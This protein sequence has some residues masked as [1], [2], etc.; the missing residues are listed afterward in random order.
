[1]KAINFNIKQRTEFIRNEVQKGNVKI[2]PN[3]ALSIQQHGHQIFINMER[4]MKKCM[5][6]ISP[7]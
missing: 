2:L 1:M 6:T 4:E 5:I 7:T 3:Y